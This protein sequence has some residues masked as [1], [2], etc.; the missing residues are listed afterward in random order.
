MN[1]K[2]FEFNYFGE[3]TYIIWDADSKE[4]AIV[5]PGMINPDEV[6]EVEDFL[7]AGGL[8]LRYILLTHIHL[9]HTF[10]IDALKEK[11]DIEVLAN[12]GDVA[13]GQSRNQQARMFHLPIEL[14]PVDI[15]R[16]LNDGATLSLGKEMITVIHTPGHSMGGICFFVPESGFVLTGD[17]LFRGSIGRTDLPGGNH[18]QLILSI[19]SK[20]L[21]LPS[22]T[23]VYPG[24]GPSTT[25]AEEAGSNPFL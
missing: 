9:D 12:K 4:A 23:K 2:R 1:I 20:L 22:D 19:R 10:G 15:D 14:G 8:K 16:F 24:H 13:L 11:Y 6:D 25:I 3:N 5:D 17:T 21:T 7:S 18:R